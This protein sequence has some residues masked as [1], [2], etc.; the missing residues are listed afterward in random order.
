MDNVGIV[1]EDL[2]GAVAFFEALGLE[3]EGGT[4]VQGPWVDR[5]VALD[6]V[7]ADIVMMRTP[8]GHSRL[9]LTRFQQPDAVAT[10]RNAPPHALGIR[11]VMFAVDDLDDTVARVRA[12]GAEL[13]GDVV[14]Y[15]DQYRLCYLRGPEGILVALAEPLR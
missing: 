6:D 12:R 1:L 15:E 13:V 4:T 9:E 10:E 14:R 5:I 8:D 2:E 7:H 3:T 11:R